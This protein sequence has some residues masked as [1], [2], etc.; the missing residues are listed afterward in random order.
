[1]GMLALDWAE[2]KHEELKRFTFVFLISLRHV[3]NNDPLELI[4]IDQHRRL[5]TEKVSE[6]EIKAILHAKN[7]GDVLILMDG[8]DEY[9]EGTNE[10]ID[11]LILSGRGNCLLVVSSRSGNFLQPIRN[12]MDEE[13]QIT[14]FSYDN[15]KKCA[16][17]YLGSRYSCPD[18]LEQAEQAGI[19]VEPQCFPLPYHSTGI[20]EGML[21]VPIILLMACTLFIE[22]KASLPSSKTAL[23]REIILMC[24]S[25]TTLKT[26]GKTAREMEDL[27]E[28]MTK[29]GK[30]AWTALTR[31]NKQLLLYKVKQSCMCVKQIICSISTDN[32]PILNKNLDKFTRAALIKI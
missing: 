23:F 5:K 10:E 28:M 30:L 16:A 13:I 32:Q 4:I 31:K 22:N 7:A 1:M 21:H 6:N 14:G 20:N 27:S 24:I 15:M 26:L 8:Y 12:H 18:F 9:V 3:D 2:N 17:Q 19:H 29:L 25:R 11:D